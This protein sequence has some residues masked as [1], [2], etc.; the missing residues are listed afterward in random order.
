MTTWDGSCSSVYTCSHCCGNRVLP[1]RE[2]EKENPACLSDTFVFL[3]IIID[4]LLENKF[5]LL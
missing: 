2:P 3:L 5:E 4:L 1:A